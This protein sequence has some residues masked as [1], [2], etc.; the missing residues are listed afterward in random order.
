MVG[1]ALKNAVFGASEEALAA[2]PKFVQKMTSFFEGSFSKVGGFLKGSA[3]KVLKVAGPVAAIVAAGLDISEATHKFTDTVIKAGVDPATAKIAAG[4]T[5]LINTLTFGLLPDGIQETIAI[6]LGKLGDSLFKAMDDMLGPGFS[7]SIKEYLGGI[8]QVFTGIGDLIK[9]LWEG[10]SG[11]VNQALSD[12]AEGTI[13][14][15]MGLFAMAA[16]ALLKLG[17]LIIEKL[18]AVVGWLSD[19]IKRKNDMKSKTS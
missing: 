4:T 9:G 2:S 10:D 5:G 8:F 17:P 12:I 11:K 19:K 1:Q 18:L 16:N 14:D 13:R 6:Q 7:A 15:L 3:G